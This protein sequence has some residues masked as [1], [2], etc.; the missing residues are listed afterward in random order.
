MKN[1][2]IKENSH[3]PHLNEKKKEKKKK[4]EP[5]MIEFNKR[6]VFQQWCDE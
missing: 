5:R 3:Q 2:K 6:F 1:N 4:L